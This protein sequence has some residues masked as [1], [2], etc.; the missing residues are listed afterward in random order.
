MMETDRPSAKLAVIL[1]ADILDSTS[2]VQQDEHLAHERI[3]GCFRRFGDTIEKYH[4]RV[5]EL[6]GDALLAEFERASDA[7][8]AA[9][10]FQADQASYIDQLEDEIKP[11]ARIGIAMGEVVIADNTLTGAGVVLSQRVEQLAQAGGVC[12]TAAIHEGLPQRLPFDQQDIGEQQLKGFDERIRVYHIALASGKSIPPP[13]QSYQEKIP[14]KYHALGAGIIVLAI[15]AGLL[16]WQTSGRSSVEP[17]SIERMAYPLPDKP[18]IAVLPFDNL[19]EDPSQGYFADGMTEDLITDLSKNPG[20]FVIARNSSFSYKGQPVKIREVAEQLGVRYV[21]E[22][23]VRRSGDQMRINAQLIDAITGGH[24]W[25]ERYDG[26]LSDVFT[27]QDKVIVQ[28]AEALAITLTRAS[29]GLEVIETDV[30]GAYDAFLQ[31]WSHYLRHSQEDYVKAI[32]FFDK[33]VALDPNYSRAYA[34]LARVY[35]D[36]SNL[37]W[38]GILGIEWEVGFNR[39]L[40]A[41]EMSMRKPSAE[42]YAIRAEMFALSGKSDQALIEINQAL[43]QLPNSANYIS[44]AK[45]LNILGQAEEAEHTVRQA[46]RMDPNVLPVILRTLGRSLLHQQRYQ[47]AAEAMQRAI[48]QQPDHQ[49]SYA[50]LASIYGH[51]ERIDDASNSI[52]KYNE[53]VAG[54]NYTPLTVQEIGW[55][56]DGD[57]YSYDRTYLQQVLEGLRKAGVPEG[58]APQTE[59]FEFTS[60]V[61]Q[62]DPGYQVEGALTIDVHAAKALHDQNVT[63][64]DVRDP[65]SWGRRRIPGAFNLDLNIDFDEAQLSN[66]INKNDEVVIHCWGETCSWAAYACAK[67]SRWGFKRVHYFAG[68]ISA[69]VTA[70][71]AVES[72]SKE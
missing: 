4:G 27:L 40:A 64:I 70:G 43:A 10:D 38:E 12:I 31:G 67:A 30:P 23:S 8:C 28:I 60:L 44:K 53:I 32:E 59:S 18:S 20:L 26:S 34:G 3:Q 45:I 46:L 61:R 11:Q 41:L 36:M 5:R 71:Y 24:I 14:K 19:S 22:G 48:T 50:T 37:G 55:W 49:Y 51:L 58:A 62:V 16:V 52:A 35:W 13:Q 17:A 6:R 7:V 21:L 68:G 1:H 42:A 25:A 39:A 57:M 33:A 56:W 54:W 65:G 15:T 2:L 72:D 29:A 66:R 9:L 47:E 69:W 63:F